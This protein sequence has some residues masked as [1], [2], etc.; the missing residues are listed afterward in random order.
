MATVAQLIQ[1]TTATS[2]STTNASTLN[3]LASA[4][5][6]VSDIKDNTT[7]KPLDV[8]VNVSV[9]SSATGTPVNK[10][11]V[12]FA[13]ASVDGTNFQSGPETGS[14]ATDEPDLTFLG[15]IPCNTLAAAHSRNFSIFS[16]YGFVPAKFKI[17]IKNDIGAV[18][19][20]N[21]LTAGSVNT[22][23]VTGQSV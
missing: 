23:D 11:V 4:N 9:T 7:S 21:V 14:S 13:K 18:T 10:Q 2:L 17:I 8:I 16:A 12:V 5:Y 1:S 6:W 22:F 15:T 3:A 20:G 19:T